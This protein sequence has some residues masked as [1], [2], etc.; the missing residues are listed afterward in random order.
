MSKRV[1]KREKEEVE[2]EYRFYVLV[3]ETSLG[4]NT[5]ETP[6]SLICKSRPLKIRW[7]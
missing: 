2:V 6:E 4:T 1:F 7:T 5:F 3:L